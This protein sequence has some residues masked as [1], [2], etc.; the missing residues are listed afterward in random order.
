M[1]QT[2][3]VKEQIVSVDA[4]SL[5]ANNT[6]VAAAC[7]AVSWAAASTG[8]V[9]TVQSN[10]TV[11]FAAVSAGVGGSTGSTDNL[12]LR[13][14]GAGGAT[15][16]NS[17]WLIPD[18]YTSSPNAT[19]N[20]LSLQAT[21]SSTNVSVS[22]VPKGTGAFSLAVP[23]GTTAGGNAR[24][25]NAVDLRTASRFAASAV[26]S[27]QQSLLG[28]YGGTASG[29]GSIAFGAGSATGT[30]SVNF[31]TGI[32]SGTAA[33]LAAS[34]SN[35]AIVSGPRAVGFA[36]D[37]G[38][39]SGQNAF[40]HGE[41]PGWG[42][43]SVTALNA[44]G[45]QGA[46][47]TATTAF[48]H[49]HYALS[50]RYGMLAHASGAFNTG[51][52]GDCQRVAFI[53]RNKTTTNSSVTLFLDGSSARLTIPSGKILHGMLYVLGAKSDGTAVAS[54]TRQ[55]TIKNVGGTTALVGTVNTIG[56]DEAA[57]TSLAVTADNTNDA[58]DVAPAGVFNET[59][60]WTGVFCGIELAYGT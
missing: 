23:D 6:A 32:C 15:L 10:G 27:G 51:A 4:K 9:L 56:T 18:I 60:R 8:D 41:I 37:G 52:F 48:A 42:S 38:A 28:P 25:A 39:V 21:G 3:V 31:G 47:S 14:D 12:V 19:V 22:I 30:N 29:E 49:G 46:S 45:L 54:Y 44:V 34:N 33:F 17:G 5:L 11:A 57:G 16:Q 2:A 50:D 7:Q 20:H 43:G 35:T 36:R 40:G 59:W 1:G 13:A 24:G 55:V 58:L 53:L 26:A